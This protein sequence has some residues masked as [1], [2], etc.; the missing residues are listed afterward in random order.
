VS[1]CRRRPAQGRKYGLG[2][3]LATQQFSGLRN[4][5]TNN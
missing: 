2:M 4:S 1:R 5:V 3:L